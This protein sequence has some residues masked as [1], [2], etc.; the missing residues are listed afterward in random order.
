MLLLKYMTKKRSSKNEVNFKKRNFRQSFFERKKRKFHFEINSETKRGILAIFCFVLFIITILSFFNLAGK[1]GQFVFQFLKILFGWASLIPLFILIFFIWFLFQPE[2][3]PLKFF[4]LL[5]LVLFVLSLTSLFQWIYSQK[6]GIYQITL[7]QGG[8]YLG[9]FLY[10]PLKQIMGP[11]ASLVIFLAFSLISLLLIFETSLKKITPFLFWSRKSELEKKSEILQKPKPFAQFWLKHTTNLLNILK[12][13]LRILRSLFKK[14]E[15]EEKIAF[16]KKEIEREETKFEEE[17]EKIL[18]PTK[19]LEQLKIFPQT[20]IR[21]RKINLPLELLSEKSSPPTS[22]DI[23]A[24]KMIIQKTLENFNISCEMGEVQVGPTVTQYTLKPTEGI[25]LSQIVSLNND[26][27]LALASHPIRIEA[28][29]PGKSL[30]GIE[31]PNQ[32]VALIRLK[33]ILVSLE[34]K[35]KKSNLTIAL[36]KDVA[37]TPWVADLEEMPHLLLAGATGSGKTV[38]LNSIIVSLLYQN[39]P[40]ELKLIL[41]DPKRVEL[42]IYDDIPYLLTPVLVEIN[43]TI[44]ALRW[45]VS[46]M[47]RRFEI[48]SESGQRDIQSYNQRVE[49]KLPF[50]IVVIDELADLMT[51]APREIETCIIR[52]AQMAR[53]T[54]IHLVMA[55][56]RPSVDIITGLIKANITSRIAFSVASIMDSRTILDFAGAEKLLGKGDMLF[57]SPRLSKPKR[58]QGAFVSDREIKNIVNHLKEKSKPEYKEEILKSVIPPSEFD[59]GDLKEDELLPEAKEIILKY[60]KASASLL[61]RRLRI[62]YARAARLLDLLEE[63]GIIGPAEGAKPREILIEDIEEKTQEDF[64]FNNKEPSD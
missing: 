43:K 48:L 39:S 63:E 14:T 32:E 54:G 2:K 27:A 28:P 21:Q 8:G 23:K 41:I 33:E 11:W 26:L 47:E 4:R 45:I 59:F 64:D 62:G 35:K 31:V 1:T 24:N 18:K 25:R 52:L 13:L 16:T 6:T 60:K 55:T 57:M 9:F 53:A 44:N 58:L 20:E 17:P 15:T 12:Y 56:Q 3:Y 7:G 19:P 51:A 5:G 29:I 10:R 42:T 46:E 49:E 50:I 40:S 36:G 38:M 30:V 22:G 61:Q 37:G 34:F